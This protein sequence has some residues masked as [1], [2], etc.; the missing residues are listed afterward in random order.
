MTREQNEIKIDVSGDP[1]RFTFGDDPCY[2]PGIQVTISLPF[3]GDEGLWNLRPNRWNS[4][5]PFGNIRGNT[6]V[7]TFQQPL[8]QP[9]E[10]IRKELDEN[11]RRIRDYSSWQKESIDTFNSTLPSNIRAVVDARRKQLEKHD[12]L[13]AILDIPLSRDPQAPEMKSI[14]VERKI[15]KPL[16]PPPNGGYKREWE[17][18]E[19]EYQNI[20][21]IL[22]HEG[23]TFEATPRTYAVHDEEELRD[24]ML[25]HLNGHYKGDAS[26]ETFRKFGKT[27]IKIEMENRA[28][29]VAECKIWGGPKTVSDSI[30]QL[31]GYLTWRDCKTAIVIFNKHVAGF[32]DILEKIQPVLE[33]H[34]RFM[35]LDGTPGSGEWKCTFRSQD[36]DARL[37]QINLF[38]FNVFIKTK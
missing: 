36:D 27:D 8:D 16:P 23:R 3:S 22:R 31:L 11:V 32:T 26:G 15:I 2:V 35:K 25:A 4:V 6:L 1:R 19:Q 12:A 28:A 17:I 14:N 34:P 37:I 10:N 21:S 24:I 29:F 9:L 13:G 33:E 30:D 38:M 5:L 18:P 20:L 7:M